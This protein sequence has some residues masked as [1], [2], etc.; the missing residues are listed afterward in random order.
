MS[1]SLRPHGLQPIRLLCPWDSP[2]KNTGVG[3][4]FLFQGILL[5][6]GSN[7]HFLHWQAGSLPLNLKLLHPPC[8]LQIPPYRQ[9]S[10]IV[11]AAAVLDRNADTLGQQEAVV[12]LTALKAAGGAAR[13]AR[14]SRAGALAGARADGVVAVGGALERCRERSGVRSQLLAEK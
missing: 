14:E 12:T 1:E 4:H 5:T 7:P 6:Q 8:P 9:V 3:F 2:G 11:G 13:E 10:A